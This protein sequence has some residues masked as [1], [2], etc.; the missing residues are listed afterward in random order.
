V[1]SALNL[2]IYWRRRRSISYWRPAG[3]NRRP[4]GQAYSLTF[5]EFT[6]WRR[7]ISLSLASP[8]RSSAWGSRWRRRFRQRGGLWPLLGVTSRALVVSVGGWIAV[9]L[10]GTGLS[11]LAVVAGSGLIVYGATLTIA[12][13]AGIWQTPKEVGRGEVNAYGAR[14]AALA[15]VRR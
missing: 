9:H 14:T 10:A 1:A 2:Q 12:F 6:S 8:I 4:L 3:R 15:A 5:R 7:T 11:N 13:R